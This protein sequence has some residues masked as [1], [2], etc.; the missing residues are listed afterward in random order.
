MG[1]KEAKINF[2]PTFK[3]DVPPSGKRS[4][5]IRLARKALESTIKGKSAPNSTKSSLKVESERSTVNSTEVREQERW[6]ISPASSLRHSPDEIMDAENKDNEELARPRSPL[7]RLLNVL[8]FKKRC[9][10]PESSSSPGSP[11]NH[12]NLSNDMPTRAASMPSRSVLRRSEGDL[13][14]IGS[15]ERG[16][17]L[18]RSLNDLSTR[19][20]RALG[21]IEDEDA[22]K[23]VYDTSSKQRVPS[24]C[25]RIIYKSNVQFDDDSD[26]ESHSGYRIPR[27]IYRRVSQAVSPFIM[28]SRAPSP[29]SLFREGNEVLQ[30]PSSRWTRKLQKRKSRT[31]QMAQTVP[32]SPSAPPTPE[33][34][35]DPSTRGL[36][37]EDENFIPSIS[38]IDD[39]PPRP[40]RAETMKSLYSAGKAR[41]S[42]SGFGFYPRRS[43]FEGDSREREF[44][45]NGR[46]MDEP[47]GTMKLIQRLLSQGGKSPNRSL[48][49]S[50]L[51]SMR[52]TTRSKRKRRGEIVPISYDTLDDRAMHRLE[53]RSDH[54]PVLGTFAIY[55]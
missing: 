43:F 17:R 42:S 33:V 36:Q 6:V 35:S 44:D 7:K 41:R 5:S 54:R 28:R 14:S 48:A 38:I 45:N 10:S 22:I 25:D 49:P 19:R 50:R 34:G 2:A 15:T 31:P 13:L 30:D 20:A 16:S 51:G 12:P 32:S 39:D 1:F 40:K 21:D 27:R 11:D 18:M 3:Y 47:Y 4:R 53:G 37:G 9:L 24:W 26:D 8:R 55:V 29:T 52:S 46:S 23:G